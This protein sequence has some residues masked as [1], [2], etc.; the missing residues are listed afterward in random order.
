MEITRDINRILLM[1]ATINTTIN[2][3]SSSS[4]M[5]INSN[6]PPI[7]SRMKATT[8]LATFG[9]MESKK[10]FLVAILTKAVAVV[11]VITTAEG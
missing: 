10:P 2:S 8:S 7:A 11:V 5:S 3:S 9:T 4:T 6:S 1:E